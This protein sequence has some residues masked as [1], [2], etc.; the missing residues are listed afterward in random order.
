MNLPAMK[1][2]LRRKLSLEPLK[3]YGRL[4]KVFA[5]LCLLYGISFLAIIRANFS[6][7][8]DL[9]RAVEGYQGWDNFSRFASTGMSTLLHTSEHLTDI[10]PLT[11]LLAVLILALASTII[12]QIFSDGKMSLFHIFAVLPLGISPYF[13]ECISY[14]FDSPYMAM[15]ILA[16]V[17]PFVFM[18]VSLPLYAA[19]SIAGTVLMCTTYQAASGIYPMLVIAVSYAMW[20]RRDELKRVFRFIS[21]S[22]AAYLSGLL[23]YRLFIMQPLGD[24]YVS[25]RVLLSQ[26]LPNLAEYYLNVYS[27]FRK[28]WLLPICAVMLGY[29]VLGTLR[30]KRN[31]AA[32]FALAAA[33]LACMLAL[34][35]G[36][37][38]FLEKPLFVPRAMYG[39]GVLTAILAVQCCCLEKKWVYKIICAALSWCFLSFSFTY[40]NA[41]NEQKR[42]TDFRVE[43]A[44]S[45]LNSLDWS[46]EE[47]KT[48]QLEGD[49]GCAP[50]V[51]N[52]KLKYAILNRLVPVTF[53]GADT[54]WYWSDYYFWHYF[55]LDKVKKDA[56]IDLRQLDLPILKETL[57]HT[58]RGNGNYILLELK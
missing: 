6:Y 56:G 8:D 2:Q 21:V 25:N 14:K 41:L 20:S 49:I 27:D 1:A 52:A 34:T 23:M 53:G 51:R 47:V 9:A 33:A 17:F 32:S 44:I 48:L 26:V 40:G 22:A 18:R 43:M 29:V 28:L 42:Y 19:A 11:Q 12:L 36:I 24:S 38:I 16:M 57:Y 30:S 39:F 35:F 15:S 13:L 7:I 4:K 37:Y 50:A 3:A 46:G 58:I 55:N 31:K 5:V 45:D 10:S 54:D